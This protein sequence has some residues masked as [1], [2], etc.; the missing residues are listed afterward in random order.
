[1]LSFTRLQSIDRKPVINLAIIDPTFFEL[2]P[3]KTLGFSP[4]LT[5]PG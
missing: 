5:L 3:L 4:R 2:E 1:M